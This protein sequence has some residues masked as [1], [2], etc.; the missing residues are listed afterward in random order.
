MKIAY[1]IKLMRP[2]C[3]ILQGVL[4]G[5]PEVKCLFPVETWLEAPTPDMHVYEVNEVQL[6]QLI[7]RSKGGPLSL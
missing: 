5:S 4:G 2:G 7:R 3:A 6:E 1:D